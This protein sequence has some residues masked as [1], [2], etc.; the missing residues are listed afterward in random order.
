MRNVVLCDVL[1]RPREV[2]Q[3]AYQEEV[4]STLEQALQSNNVRV[5]R[6]SV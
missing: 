4:V 2:S 6:I 1:S 5:P 3:I